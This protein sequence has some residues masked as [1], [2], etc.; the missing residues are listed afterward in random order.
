M[1][2]IGPGNGKQWIE[3]FPP[4]ILVE[5][6]CLQKLHRFGWANGMFG[7]MILDLERRVPHLLSDSYQ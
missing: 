4:A 5:D 6:K 7:Q 3:W 2:K 1:E